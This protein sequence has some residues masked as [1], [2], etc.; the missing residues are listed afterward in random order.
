MSIKDEKEYE[1]FKSLMHLDSSGT[2]DDPGPYWRTGFP[3]TIEPN[4]MADNKAAVAAVMHATEK[5]LRKNLEWREI[6]ELQLRT[7]L[8]KGFAKEVTKDEIK[9]WESRGGKTY[10]IAHQ[11]VLNPHSKTTP[12]RCCFNSSQRYKGFS[13]NTSWD[14]GPDLVNS[15]HSVLLRFRK[16]TVAAQGDITKMYYMVR[17]KETE[18]W[19]QLFMWRFAGEEKLRY[20]KMERLVMGN[21]P[22]ASL[23][24]VALSETAKLEDFPKRFPAAH[25]ALTTDA[26]VDNIFLTAPDHTAIRTTIKDI[27]FVAS[28]GGFF[29]KPFI[30]LRQPRRRPWASIGK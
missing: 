25:K 12:V 21:K 16:D 23:S 5:K 9:A 20:F 26:Y 6:Y 15:L 7:L 2:A 3:W 30:I 11:M 28:K 1:R 29:F 10:Y 14:L 22:S 4:D 8:E 18:S 24:G 17:I 19:M 27:E 13:L